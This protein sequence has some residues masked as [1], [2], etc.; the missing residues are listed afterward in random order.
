MRI[1]FFIGRPL[2]NIKYL[3]MKKSIFFSLLIINLASCTTD[4]DLSGNEPQEM[5]LSFEY[6]TCGEQALYNFGSAG[7]VTTRTDQENLYVEIRANPGSSLVQSRVSL[8]KKYSADFPLTGNF[9]PGQLDNHFQSRGK[10]N[11]Y[12]YTFPLNSFDCGLY[13]IVPWATFT[14]SGRGANYAGDLPGGNGNWN[15]LEYCINYCPDIPLPFCR[16]GFMAGNTSFSSLGLTEEVW[17][18]AHYFDAEEGNSQTFR[19]F[20]EA[21]HNDLEAGYE[22]GVVTITYN[23]ETGEV[24]IE[25]DI[26]E[27]YLV[28]AHIYFDDDEPPWSSSPGDYGFTDLT[29]ESPYTFNSDDGKFWI[30]VNGMV[31]EWY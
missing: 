17:G 19:F 4:Y 31:C 12:T 16:T 15:Y 26:L 22:E 11:S 3:Y 23:D 21:Y 6:E 25:I 20:T 5:N 14:G 9:P 2:K 30:I 10:I 27:T 24:E 7:T 28:E 13:N 29:P 1:A 18:W 8:I